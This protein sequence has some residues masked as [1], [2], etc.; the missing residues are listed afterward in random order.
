M[1]IVDGLIS[2]EKQQRLRVARCARRLTKG[3]PLPEGHTQ[4]FNRNNF[5]I[6]GGDYGDEFVEGLVGV[7]TLVSDLDDKVYVHS[8]SD[9][10][11][12]AYRISDIAHYD[13]EY[14]LVTLEKVNNA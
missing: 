5:H 4:L 1:S 2:L 6:E 14:F 3:E 7:H 8:Y 11:N 10:T 13:S 12:I 9:D